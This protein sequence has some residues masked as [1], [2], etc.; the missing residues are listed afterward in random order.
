MVIRI[1]TA[2]IILIVCG[3]AAFYYGRTIAN[4]ETAREANQAHLNII[5]AAAKQ[6]CIKKAGFIKAVQSSGF[7]Y[8]ETDPTRSTEGLPKKLKHLG[9][10]WPEGTTSAIFVAIKPQVGL[11][12]PTFT[13]FYFDEKDCWKPQ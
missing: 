2:I 5:V 8:H 11:V 1:I 13:R 9:P 3:L 10:K 4:A 12:P 6:S 7:F